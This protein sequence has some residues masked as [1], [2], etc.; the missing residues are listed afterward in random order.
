M[1][2]RISRS[3]FLLP[4]AIVEAGR[5]SLLF[6]TKDP[7]SWKSE[8][9]M[10]GR[11]CA[12]AWHDDLLEVDRAWAQTHREKFGKW[13]KDSRP[14]G[15]DRANAS[16]S[17]SHQEASAEELAAPW[18]MLLEAVKSA[19]FAFLEV[20]TKEKT[21]ADR[22]TIDPRERLERTYLWQTLNADGTDEA[23]RAAALRAFR[24]GLRRGRRGRP[25]SMLRSIPPVLEPSVAWGFHLKRV[26]LPGPSAARDRDLMAVWLE[27]NDRNESMAAKQ[28]LRELYASAWREDVPEE[29]REWAEC[30]RIFFADPVNRRRR[31]AIAQS[32]YEG[33]L[34]SSD[35]IFKGEPAK[36]WS[37]LS[38]YAM[39]PW[40]S[41]T[42]RVEDAPE[43]ESEL[44]TAEAAAREYWDTLY[45]EAPRWDGDP[46]QAHWLAA[47]RAARKAAADYVPPEK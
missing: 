17:D 20:S 5:G 2:L 37:G 19:F 26:T 34:G 8:L 14:D 15:I 24:R 12:E 9:E 41:F 13:I 11:V 39:E 16:S 43:G 10:L 27:T 33:F 44:A 29:D 23:L 30:Y 40:C 31:D 45:Q 46:A 18:P 38:R 6:K 1:R 3:S 7:E 35:G 22:E 25:S 4:R 36:P 32:A 47:A 28:A 42:D 21:E